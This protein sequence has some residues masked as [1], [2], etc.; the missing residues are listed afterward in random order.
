MLL[1]ENT[2]VSFSTKS[3]KTWFS[4]FSRHLEKTIEVWVWEF[5]LVF[6]IVHQLFPCRLVLELLGCCFSL[7]FEPVDVCFGNI[8]KFI[9]LL[10]HIA[11]NWSDYSVNLANLEFQWTG[12][13]PLGKRSEGWLARPDHVRGY[14]A[15]K[16]LFSF[17]CTLP[18]SFLN[19]RA[20]RLFYHFRCLRYRTAPD[21]AGTHSDNFFGSIAFEAMYWQ[22]SLKARLFFQIFYS[23]LKNRHCSSGRWTEALTFVSNPAN[24]VHFLFFNQYLARQLPLCGKDSASSHPVTQS[25]VVWV[26]NYLTLFL[27]NWGKNIKIKINNKF[28]L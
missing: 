6:T 5:Y 7:V 8:G 3:D 19:F 16:W 15:L 22:I 24:Q 27:L 1:A 14:F 26:F 23:I 4:L 12:Q 10:K 9:S 2:W 21:A 13:D 28:F 20:K 25:F 18:S 17:G 11:P